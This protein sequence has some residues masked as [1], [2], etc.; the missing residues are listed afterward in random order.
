FS[1]RRTARPPGGSVWYILTGQ[2]S[3]Y[4]PGSHREG[5]PRPA[6]IRFTKRPLRL[7]SELPTAC[8]FRESGAV[9]SPELHD[10]ADFLPPAGGFHPPAGAGGPRSSESR[11]RVYPARATA[12]VPAAPVGLPGRS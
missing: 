7:T 1:G 8:T 3:G 11:P 6:A 9:P 5:V 4:L 2:S 10:V 12:V